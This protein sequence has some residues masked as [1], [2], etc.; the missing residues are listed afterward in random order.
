MQSDNLVVAALF[1]FFLDSVERDGDGGTD[2]GDS[3]VSSDGRTG[4]APCRQRRDHSTIYG[5]ADGLAGSEVP[6]GPSDG[7]DPRQHDQ[8]QAIWFIT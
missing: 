7:T 5:G 2:H 6:L 8:A 1:C 4:S 3:R